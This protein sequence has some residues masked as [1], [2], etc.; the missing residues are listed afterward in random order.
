M[1]TL[2][3]VGSIHAL[4]RR[5]W[6][7]FY[8]DDPC[9]AELYI[10]VREYINNTNL[11]ANLEEACKH[12]NQL[13]IKDVRTQLHINWQ[14]QIFTLSFE[15]YIPDPV[16]VYHDIS[17]PGAEPTP[18]IRLALRILSI[19]PNS[20][21]CE[22]LF[23][24]FGLILTKLRTRLSTRNL[25]NLAEFKLHLRDE[26]MCLEVKKKLRQWMFGIVKESAATNTN[27]PNANAPEN[28]ADGNP[29]LSQPSTSLSSLPE[30]STTSTSQ[31][32]L[33]ALTSRLI[34]MLDADIDVD[35]LV[36][37]PQSELRSRKWPIS[38]LFN[39]DAGKYWVSAAQ[40]SAH[41]SLEQEMEYYDL[42]DLDAAG[43]P[44]LNYDI[45]DCIDSIFSN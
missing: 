16:E 18:L 10:E 5:L 45:D 14:T 17:V 38:D 30:A 24:T 15:A 4:L 23:S 33:Q 43:E 42:L 20:A 41:G 19:C 1:S 2:I 40:R 37:L 21:S 32:S 44:D 28:P 9:P 34:T 39:F 22:H 12:L 13:A 31:R 36:D 29:G 26:N 8:P 3:S 27:Q 35:L 11:Y 25:V 7:R 6:E